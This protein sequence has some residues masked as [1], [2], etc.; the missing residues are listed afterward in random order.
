MYED[1][2]KGTKPTANGESHARKKIVIIGLGMVAI[3]FM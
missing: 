3:S 1:T 2:P